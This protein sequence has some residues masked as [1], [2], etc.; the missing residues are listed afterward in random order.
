LFSHGFSNNIQPSFRE[1]K[2]KNERENS[3]GIFENYTGASGNKTELSNY[4]YF[5]LQHCKSFSHNFILKLNKNFQQTGK[6]R[7]PTG[8]EVVMR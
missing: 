5:E 4:Y 3:R 2:W 1:K 7:R 6:D 8:T